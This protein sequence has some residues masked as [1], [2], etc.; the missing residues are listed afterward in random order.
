MHG[1]RRLE[2]KTLSA[3]RKQA[4]YTGERSTKC[5]AVPLGKFDPE[6][7]ERSL[8]AL[9]LQNELHAK[10]DIWNFIVREAKTNQHNSDTRLSE[11]KFLAKSVIW[12]AKLSN[13]GLLRTIETGFAEGHSA[14]SMLAASIGQGIPHE[15]TAFDPY[16][17]SDYQNHGRDAVERL[18]QEAGPEHIEN[19]T[20]TM[21]A[22]SAGIGL[23]KMHEMGKCVHIA[24][25]DDGHKFD[26]NMVELY[27]INKMMPPGGLLVMDD[28]WMPSVASTANF[29]EQNLPFKRIHKGPQFHAFLKTNSDER[30]WTHFESFGTST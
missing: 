30:K 13:G 15:H 1:L 5:D 29:I 6:D 16:E 8:T 9:D 2:Q 23:A 27:F 10:P 11:M 26:D 17:E 22:Q 21:S 4:P 7:V 12:S 3:K 14:I 19:S 28:I 20:F 25:M 18:R 24:Y